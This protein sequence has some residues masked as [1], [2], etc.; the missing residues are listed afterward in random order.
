MWHGRVRAAP[1]LQE[2]TRDTWSIYLTPYKPQGGVIQVK[3]GP[4]AVSGPRSCPVVPGATA[5]PP[6]AASLIATAPCA[7]ASVCVLPP[8]RTHREVST[9]HARACICPPWPT[10]LPVARLC[11]ITGANDARDTGSIFL[12]PFKT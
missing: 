7:V 11:E 6:P 12:S 8:R 4:L 2:G 5:S 10:V 1:L 3:V 9:A